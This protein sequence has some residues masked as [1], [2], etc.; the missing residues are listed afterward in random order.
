MKKS[1]VLKYDNIHNILLSL[2]NFLNTIEIHDILPLVDIER[3]KQLKNTQIQIQI[4]LLFVSCKRPM[5][6]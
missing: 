2:A 5:Q 1:L 3:T 4:H 6:I